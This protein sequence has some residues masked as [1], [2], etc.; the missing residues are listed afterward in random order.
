MP[1]TKHLR[2]SAQ[3]DLFGTGFVRRQNTSR[4]KNTAEV[5]NRNWRKKKTEYESNSVLRDSVT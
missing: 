4:R 2:D 5:H 1:T 3:P